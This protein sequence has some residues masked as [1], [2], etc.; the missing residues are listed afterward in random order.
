MRAPEVLDT[1]T[2]KGRLEQ[3]EKNDWRWQLQHRIT[4]LGELE[5]WVNLTEIGRAVV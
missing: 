2:E 5:K 3:E 4:T 1:K